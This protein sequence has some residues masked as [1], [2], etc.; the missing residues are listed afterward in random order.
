MFKPKY[1]L[2]NS[3]VNNLTTISECKSVIDR[4]KILPSTE[5]KLRRLALTRMS[6]SSTAIEGNQL[7]IN[8]VEAI[9]AGKTI[10][11][12]ERDIYE[13]KNYLKALKY[14][15]K[16]VKTNKKITLRST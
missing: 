13:V 12:S 1:T 14:I 11:A 5:I 10:D 9:I 16:L 8:Q 2:T 6:Q 7:N 4:A 15:D 3:I